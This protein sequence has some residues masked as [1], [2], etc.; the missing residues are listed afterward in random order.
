MLVQ[1]PL[2]VGEVDPGAGKVRRQFHGFLKEHF[3][4]QVALVVHGDAGKGPRRV[5][6]FR[7]R[8]QDLPVD[9]FGLVQLVVA[10]VLLRLPE[11]AREARQPAATRTP[12]HRGSEFV[13]FV[14]L[15]LRLAQAGIEFE[16]ARVGGQCALCIV[17]NQEQVAEDIVGLGKIRVVRQCRVRLLPR[18]LEVAQH[19]VGASREAQ[20]VAV[21]GEHGEGAF[22][23][24]GCRCCLARTQQRGGAG[25]RFLPGRGLGNL[26]RSD[27][28]GM[29]GI[30]QVCPMKI[31]RD[32]AR[33]K[34][35]VISAELF[36]RPETNAESIAAQVALLREHVDGILLTDNQAGR[37]HLSPVA[38]AS[39]V[40]ANG[41]DAIVQLGCRNRNRVALLAELLGAAA[42]G[43][44]SVVLTRG[45]RV[46]EGF[47]PRPKAVLDVKAAEL[48]AIAARL[49]EEDSV[50]FL[51][52]LYVGSD[53]TLHRPRK[54][55]QPVK[56]Q[57][58]A[59]A[60][61]QFLLSNICMNTRLVRNYMAYVVG[62][63]LPRQL[64]V[65]VS[66]AVAGSA[67]DA[68][69]L[70]DARPNNLVP[71]ELIARLEQSADP[72]QEGIRICAEQLR[73][74]AAIPGVRGAHLVATRN[75]AAIPAAI[76][77]AG[78]LELPMGAI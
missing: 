26:R 22:A 53:F 47:N 30:A 54:D 49:K 7:V 74:L 18:K 32:A 33:R 6:M 11:V 25:E 71:D 63:G 31:F 16:R 51:P 72:E 45:Q 20:Q 28:A 75:L 69:F 50:R 3:G 19:E 61:A 52:D 9:G 46:P 76:A 62:K 35:F 70:R 24:L 58:K 15:D 4:F 14:S 59:E 13:R 43:V 60:G 37:L 68:R 67:D 73:E 40:I 78:L 42:L 38:A 57:S 44:S 77:A 41:A 1:L 17:A 36:L 12:R 29:A 39:L 8:A 21:R 27:I 64:N 10:L 55:W 34:D 65:H 66:L 48:V 56:L 23:G 2:D 5:D